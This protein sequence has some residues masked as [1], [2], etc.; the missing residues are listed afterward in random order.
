MSIKVSLSDL[1]SEI[2]KW[3]FGFL[4]TSGDGGTHVI[5]LMPEVTSGEDGAVQLGFDAAGGRAGRNVAATPAVTIAFPPRS[6]GDGFSLLVDGKADVV[7]DLVVVNPT[8]AVLHRPA[9]PLSGLRRVDWVTADEYERRAFR[10]GFVAPESRS[11]TPDPASPLHGHDADVRGFV[12]S[13]TFVLR[14]ANGDETFEAGTGFEL[15]TGTLHA[16]SS[17]DDGAIVLLALR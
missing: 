10:D 7:D 9:P 4:I 11:F 16:E 2:P 5:S 13:G 14:M 8:G 1:G 15:S 17:G 12:V 3:G 6:E